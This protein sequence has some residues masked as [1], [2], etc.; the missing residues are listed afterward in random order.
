MYMYSAAVVCTLCPLPPQEPSEAGDPESV[1][2]LPETIQGVLE[3]YPGLHDHVLQRT[4]KDDL[5]HLL[6]TYHEASVR[7][8][9]VPTIP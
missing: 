5:D 8:A 4:L 7:D 1:T 2:S 9:E 3:V 6:Q